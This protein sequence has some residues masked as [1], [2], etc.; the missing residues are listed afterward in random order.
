[1]CYYLQYF[2]S[3]GEEASKRFRT[4]TCKY[5]ADLTRCRDGDVIKV[6]GGV[7]DSCY[8]RLPRMHPPLVRPTPPASTVHED[9]DEEVV[10]VLETKHTLW[11]Q[12]EGF[13][14]VDPWERDR[15]KVHQALWG[16]ELILIDVDE[17][18]EQ[19]SM[20]ATASNDEDPFGPRAR[21][22]KRASTLK[23][24]LTHI[25]KANEDSSCCQNA[26]WPLNAV[27]M[28]NRVIDDGC[29]STV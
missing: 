7:C 1:M 5:V 13:V 25:N 12:Q 24:L 27:V 2:R 22:P 23:R 15:E 28:E 4:G 6:I 14:C 11:S 20:T 9:K 17:K 21:R 10:W 18:T 29:T 19:S 26:E 8:R 3:C 16:G